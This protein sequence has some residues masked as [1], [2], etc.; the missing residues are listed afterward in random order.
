MTEL[1]E[2]IISSEEMKEIMKSPEFKKMVEMVDSGRLLD[3]RL[4]EAAKT[5][6]VVRKPKMKGVIGNLFV[7]PGQ[8]KEKE[9]E[10]EEEHCEHSDHS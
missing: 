7:M 3:V 10:G 9:H 8:V 6:P 2:K 4:L 5:T 1:P